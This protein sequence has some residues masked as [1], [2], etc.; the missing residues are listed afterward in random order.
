MIQEFGVHSVLDAGCG[1]YEYDLV[2]QA[3]MRR[4][5]VPEGS[6]DAYEKTF[7]GSGHANGGA[8]FLAVHG[9]GK[10]YDAWAVEFLEH[11]NLHHYNHYSVP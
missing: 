7:A 1:E 8:R 9:N 5:P 6:H 4:R 11:V 10:T 3:S 2:P